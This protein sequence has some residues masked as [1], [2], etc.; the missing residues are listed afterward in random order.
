MTMM[1]APDLETG[2]ALL[3]HQY[4]R[5]LRR[6]A[7]LTGEGVYKEYKGWKLPVT[8]IRKYAFEADFAL[9]K[10]AKLA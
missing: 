2:L 8:G 3:F 1:R 6:S 10:I 4:M 5:S 9:L 7:Q